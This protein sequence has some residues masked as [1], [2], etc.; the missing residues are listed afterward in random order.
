MFLTVVELPL[1]K[2]V[3]VFFASRFGVFPLA[4]RT[5]F[6]RTQVLTGF[7]GTP[8]RCRRLHWC[9]NFRTFPSQW[10][11]FRKLDQVSCGT[12]LFPGTRLL[13]WPAPILLHPTPLRGAGATNLGPQNNLPICDPRLYH[14]SWITGIARTPGPTSGCPFSGK[15]NLGRSTPL[16]CVLL[17]RR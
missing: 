14:P 3:T 2:A 9:R 4:T 7:L 15:R 12:Y 1:I 13:Q 17:G 6:Y 5:G 10:V 8:A 16:L 11:Y